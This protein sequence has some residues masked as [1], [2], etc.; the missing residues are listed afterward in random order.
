MSEK[1]QKKLKICEDCKGN[2]Y[3][4][5]LFEEGREELITD[6]KPCNNQEEVHVNQ[7]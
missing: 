1:E 4:K 7:E 6:C 5:H 3:Q 2:G